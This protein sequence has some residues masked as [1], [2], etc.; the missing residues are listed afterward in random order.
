MESMWYKATT[1]IKNQPSQRATVGFYC[2]D[3]F[4][5][6]NPKINCA[7]KPSPQKTMAKYP[8]QSIGSSKSVRNTS[9]PNR[10]AMA[11]FTKYVLL[12]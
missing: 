7:R 8:I 3:V 11:K 5:F 4:K 12:V 10:S 1:Q 9:K 6:L 2:Y